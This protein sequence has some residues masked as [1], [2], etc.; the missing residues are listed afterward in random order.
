MKGKLVREMKGIEKKMQ[1]N[2]RKAKANER[3]MKEIDRKYRKIKEFMQG[4]NDSASQVWIL[5]GFSRVF[6]GVSM[7]CCRVFYS[8]LYGCC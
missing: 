1:G 2:E 6:C 7:D 5:V 8:V 3:K 4:P